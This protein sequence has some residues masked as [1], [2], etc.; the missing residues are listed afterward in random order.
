[1][2]PAT[3]GRETTRSPISKKRFFFFFSLEGLEESRQLKRRDDEPKESWGPSG[4]WATVRLCRRALSSM[5]SLFLPSKRSKKIQRK[6]DGGGDLLSW[7]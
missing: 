1:M 2:L 6:R 5:L 4:G 3:K 7:R